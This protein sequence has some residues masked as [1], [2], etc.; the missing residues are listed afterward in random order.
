MTPATP[1]DPLLLSVIVP[2]RN[3]AE[4]LGDCLGSLTA[5]SEP[6][7]A[8]GQDWELFCVD[9]ASMDRTRV[10]ARSFAGVTLLDAPLLAPGWTGKSAAIWHGVMQARGAVLLFTDADTIHEPGSLQRALHE[11]EKHGAAMLSYSP[12]QIVQ[13]FWQRALMPLVFSELNIAFPPAQVSDPAS[14]VAAANGQFLMAEREAYFK[15]GGHQAVAESVLEDV[16][17]AARFKRAGMAIRFRYAPDA[18]AVRMYRSLSAMVEGW[19][20]NLALLFPQPLWL[21]FMRLLDFCLI[22]GIPLLLWILPQVRFLLWQ[23]KLALALVWIWV[24]CRC[25]LRVA[26]SQFPPLDCILSIAGLP[27]F[28]ALLVRSW[29]H[30]HL[31]RRVSWKGREYGA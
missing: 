11:R 24:L 23:Q 21:A 12:R 14:P 20:K 29:M 3:E 10:I 8:L 5:Q 15:I 31:R 13:G 7:F 19:T 16:A 1:G 27:L 17:L 22:I 9:D 6:G 2:A 4:C 30:H 28:V 18:V 26:K 25:F